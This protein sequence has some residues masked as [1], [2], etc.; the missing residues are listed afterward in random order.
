[1]SDHTTNETTNEI[2]YG[3]CHCG[4]GQPAPIAKKTSKK[5]DWV[6]G[7]PVRYIIGHNTKVF[8]VSEER[9]WCKVNKEGPIHAI[10]NTACWIWIGS[11]GS[12]GY[13][14][15]WD[16]T[17]DTSAHR[18]SYTL[19]YGEIPDGL[20]VLHRCDNPTC[21]RPDHLFLGTRQDNV[22]DMIAKNRHRQ[23]HCPAGESNPSAKLT[24]S[25]VLTIR[26]MAQAGTRQKLIA[27]QFGVSPT[28]IEK[29]TS[30]SVWKHI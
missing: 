29:I 28:L 9:F 23:G 7:K 19:H 15:F 3:Y 10:L 11:Y 14:R 20:W 18:Y 6:K 26:A 25:D 12:T 5:N 30:R 8:S 16:G 27:E 4:C 2:P 21:V 1:M 22:D 24:E 13:G 17:R